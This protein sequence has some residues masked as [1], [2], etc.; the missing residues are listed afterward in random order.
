VSS[1]TYPRP[2]SIDSLHLNEAAVL[3]E[4]E[5]V[6]W[7]ETDAAV[8]AR[9]VLK[10]ER[11][12]TLKALLGDNPTLPEGLIA[13]GT[14]SLVIGLT[15]DG[16]MYEDGQWVENEEMWGATVPLS[17]DDVAFVA[18]AFSEGCDSVLFRPV[19]PLAWITTDPD[20][21][22]AA[23]AISKLPSNTKLVAIVD[24]LDK[25]A[26]LEL[27]A[28]APGPTLYRRHD[29][30]W[31]EDEQWLIPLRSIDPP[32]IV[33]LTE[34][35]LQ[36]SVIEQVDEATKGVEF[37]PKE[38]KQRKIRSSAALDVIED[39]LGNLEMQ[40]LL[41]VIKSPEGL[42]GTERLRLYWTTGQGG[43]TKIRWGTPGS[44]TRCHRHLVK[45]LGPRAK[46]YCTNLCQRMGGFGVACHVGTRGS[47][48]PLL[49]ATDDDPYGD[50]ISKE[51]RSRYPAFPATKR[52]K[53]KRKPTGDSRTPYARED[54]KTTRELSDAE[55]EQRR[56]AA[57]KSALARRKGQ[58]E[59]RASQWKTM[60]LQQKVELAAQL[61]AG[62]RRRLEELESKL[63]ATEDPLLRA[64]IQGEM[65]DIRDMLG[66]KDEWLRN[67]RYDEL[68]LADSQ[69]DK[70]EGEVDRLRDGYDRKLDALRASRDQIQAQLS[71]IKPDPD[72][73]QRRADQMA[74]KASDFQEEANALLEKAAYASPE[75]AAQLTAQANRLKDQA[76]AVYTSM[77]ENL[78]PT[79]KL[80]N[81]LAKVR[82]DISNVTS[83]KARNIASKRSVVEKLKDNRSR[84][85]QGYR[86]ASEYL[87]RR[88]GS[89]QT[90]GSFLV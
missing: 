85:V 17:G 11:G 78:D 4:L 3:D 16:L 80:R 2:S 28:L 13:A 10:N 29:G 25:N 53:L 9:R 69:I 48:A 89:G 37:I 57:R 46:G 14:D 43:L 12:R 54:R 88:R 60:N 73:I 34:E 90:E 20:P 36:G 58:S 7:H 41:A 30:K 42:K 82:M 45:Y 50:R 71:L 38:V 47:A 66:A 56:E 81:Q 87:R 72:A 51:V 33:V 49:A 26:V 15:R 65:D 44:W 31:Y 22:L 70:A 19:F 76:S 21:V 68:K 59:S 67:A 74:G 35:G 55:I 79:L 83:E 75:K 40:T 62:A 39:H 52:Y 1:R 86:D 84:L 8:W 5:L 63:R 64:D 61:E 32:P 24:E 23:A 77:D 27:I 6:E 18:R